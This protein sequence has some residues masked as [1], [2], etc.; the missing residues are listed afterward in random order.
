MT[1]SVSEQ[2]DH[3]VRRAL[4]STIADLRRPGF[5]GREREIVNLF[6]LGHLVRQRGRGGVLRDAMQIGIEVAVPQ[7]PGRGG[8]RKKPDVCKDV[9]IWA[10]PGM[11]VWG[12][13]GAGRVYPISVLEWKCVNRQDRGSSVQRKR[14]EHRADK[15]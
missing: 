3:V 13:D 7:L 11:T 8:L 6:V 12:H 2:L 4:G 10:E 1:P 14:E 15:K 9:V 5:H